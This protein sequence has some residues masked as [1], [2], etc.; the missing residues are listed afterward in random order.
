MVWLQ[1]EAFVHAP[2]LTAPQLL[3]ILQG[4]ARKPA[5]RLL[6]EKGRQAYALIKESIL[7]S[8]IAE[9]SMGA[10]RC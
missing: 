10:H 1:V 8:R 3:S 9:E 5:N 2:T 7:G 4:A 6:L